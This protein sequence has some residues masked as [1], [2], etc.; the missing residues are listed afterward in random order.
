MPSLTERLSIIIEATGTKAA[1][2][3]RKVGD[4][5]G[6]NLG[7]AEKSGGLF[8]KTLDKMGAKGALAGAA[9]ATGAAVAGKAVLDFGADAVRAASDLG[10]QQSAT[11]TIFG[12]GAGIVSDYSRT[13]AGSIGTSN[14]AAL[15]AANSFGDLFLNVGFTEKQAAH[16]SVALVQLAGDLASFKNLNPDDVLQKLQSGLVG[17]TEPLRSLG[18]VINEATVKSKAMELGL[19]GANRELTDGEKIAAR[20][21]LI[22]EKTGRAQGDVAR[23]SDS[24][25][26]SQRRANAMWE[27]S[28]AQLGK[29]LTPSVAAATS[30][31]ASMTQVLQENEEVS[32]FGLISWRKNESAVTQ[33][34]DAFF[35]F[36]SSELASVS[37]TELLRQAEEDLGLATGALATF[38]KDEG[39]AQEFAAKAADEHRQAVDKMNQA[40]IAGLSAELQYEQSLNGVEDGLHDLAEAQKA[41][42][43]A[44]AAHGSKS[45]EAKDAAEQLSRAQLSLRGDLLSV[46]AAA[47]AVKQRQF[48]A[49]GQ[50]F[51]AVDSARAQVAALQAL[52][53]QFP[54]LTAPIEAY[55][56]ELS[57][58]PGVVTTRVGQEFVARDSKGHAV[59][60]TADGGVFN[61]AQVRVIGEAGPEAVVPLSRSKRGRAAQVLAQAGLGWA[62]GGTTGTSSG[63][64]GGTTYVTIN[65][66]PGSD[67]DDVVD[68]LTRWSRR[69]GPVPIRTAG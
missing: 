5:A 20:Y 69:N 17:E 3:F 46:A 57:K 27:D 50:T 40:A 39:K 28:K 52:E 47:A 33:L 51:T 48:E 49:N 29:N 25:A 36:K 18:I 62:D 65:M 22:I 53:K 6:K 34:K 44:V 68:A 32:R 2:E 67:G 59:K 23:T 45:A 63:G 15:E 30:A 38:T 31:V 66:P 9:I 26:N 24:L 42:T 1:A 58:I 13:A 64:W 4:A 43:D 16:L 35:G 37:T 55:I 21:A 56:A 10:E 41:V 60:L 12:K 8:G 19:G 14:R 61:G 11:N 54:A 7:D